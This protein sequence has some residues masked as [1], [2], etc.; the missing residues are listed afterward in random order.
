LSSSVLTDAFTLADVTF[1]GPG[2]LIAPTA[3]T[4][5]A[6]DRHELGLS[7]QTGLDTYSLVIGPGSMPAVSLLAVAGC[8]DRRL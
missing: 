5:L 8:Q 1:S 3:R 4:R 6:D 7:G 2:G